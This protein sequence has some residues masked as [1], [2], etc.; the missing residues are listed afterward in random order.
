MYATIRERSDTVLPVPDGI[1]NT[2]W[3][4]KVLS[5]LFFHST[6]TLTYTVYLFYCSVI[7]SISV[8]LYTTILE[9]YVSFQKSESAG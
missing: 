9:D 6:N 1:S 7:R 2:Q 5:Y 4:C 8:Y 3:P